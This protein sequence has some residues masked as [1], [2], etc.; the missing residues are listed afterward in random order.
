MKNKK[1]DN[2]KVGMLVL[3]GLIFMILTLYMIG[4]NRN[5]FG[6]TFTIKAVLNNVNGLVP[7]NNV[8]F[9][10][11]D[12]GTVKSIKVE[13]DTA[14]VVTMSVDES[15]KPYIRRNAIATIGTDG[16]MGN[17][18]ININS[19]SGPALPIKQGDVIQSRKP[20]ETDEMLRTLNTTNNNIERIT[21]NLYEISVKLNSSE[22]LW[23]L[24]SDTVIAKDLKKAVVDFKRAGANTAD[25][26]ATARNIIQKLDNG[27]GLAYRLFT[28]TTLSTKLTLSLQQIEQ[29]S[30][31]TSVIMKDLKTVVDD[32]KQGD[33]TAGLLL[34]DTLLRQSLFKSAINIEQGTDR[35]NQ[36]MEALKANFLFRKYFKKLEKE[37]NATSKAKNE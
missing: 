28:D 15:M 18:L 36:N 17:K 16:L 31:Q 35:F 9:K 32:M 30:N 5:L 34:T 8:R 37:Q 2:A 33:G 1:I 14:I 24:L 3:A 23:T 12:V 25:V 10:G 22:S 7:G 4:K 19:D 20:V 27:N 11:M 29:A 6:S 13:N 21:N 26:T